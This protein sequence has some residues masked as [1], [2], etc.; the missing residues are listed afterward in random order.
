MKTEKRLRIAQVAPLW[1]L[2]P[3]ATYGGTELVVYNLTEEL[4][5][6]G[7]DVTLFASAGSQ[8]GARLVECAPAAL[9]A[10]EEQIKLDKTHCTVMAYE[11]MMMQTV[12]D[13]ADHFDIIHNHVGYQLLAFANLT[14]TPMVTTLHNALDPLPVKELFYRNA[15]LPYISISNYQQKLWPNLHYAD[16]IYHGIE[17]HRFKPSYETKDKHYFAFLGRLS[18]EKGPQ[19]AIQVAKALGARLVMAGKID[20]VDR[21]FYREQ[22]KPLVD[23]DQIQ[24]IG[25]LDHGQKVELLSNAA[26]TLFP[27]TWPEPFGLVMIESMAC[28]TPVFALRNGSVPE[29]ID[30]GKTGYIADSL[31]DLIEAVRGWREYDRKRVRKIAERRFSVARMVDDHERLYERL[32]ARNIQPEVGRRA[33]KAMPSIEPAALTPTRVAELKRSAGHASSAGA[34]ARTECLSPLE[35]ALTGAKTKAPLPEYYT[36]P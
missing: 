9:R 13:Q 4:V 20:R 17:T 5:R 30:Q 22:I 34:A 23:G 1:E 18:P 15:N 26:A 36:G 2:V 32:T 10:M 3:P 11:L 16:T 28:G 25:E 27:I 21:A 12:F 31:E 24:Y 7:H 35:S 6:R 8:T 19:H 29:V 14:R 33:V